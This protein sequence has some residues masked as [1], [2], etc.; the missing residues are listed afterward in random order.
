MKG[1]HAS[2]EIFGILQDSF[3]F[4][5]VFFLSVGTPK[6]STHT[7]RIYIYIHVIYMLTQWVSL[8]K[9]IKLFPELGLRAFLGYKIEPPRGH[10]PNQRKQF[11]ICTLAESVYI[12]IFNIHEYIYIYIS[13]M[14]N[15][16]ASRTS[17]MISI[18]VALRDLYRYAFAIARRPAKRST[19]SN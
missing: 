1:V 16:E 18:A 13:I 10:E 6:Q 5:F 7:Y 15:Q 3:R 14:L 2:K 8:R 9:Q 11:K 12:Y 19:L 17:R 4:F